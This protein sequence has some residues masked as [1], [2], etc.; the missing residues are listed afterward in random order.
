MSGRKNTTRASTAAT[1]ASWRE[2]YVSLK[3]LLYGIS[4][5]QSLPHDRQEASDMAN[6]CELARS[7]GGNLLAIEVYNVE[8]HVGHEVHLWPD[9]WG[10]VD[11]IYTEEEELAKEALRAAVD[12]RKRTFAVGSKVANA[13]NSSEIRFQGSAGDRDGEAA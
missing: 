12:Q 10:S 8:R 4:N 11:G 2:G 13:P 1:G 3:A 5:I 7:I 6:M 9:G